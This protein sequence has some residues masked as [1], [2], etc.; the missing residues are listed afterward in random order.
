M[1]GRP[2]GLHPTQRT[3]STKG[4]QRVREAAFS[5]EEPDISSSNTNGQP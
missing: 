5:W 3:I 1:K 2:G 4:R